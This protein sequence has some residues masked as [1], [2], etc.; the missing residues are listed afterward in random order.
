VR[1]D[2]AE[3]GADEQREQPAQRDEEHGR[4]HR[5]ASPEADAG[6]HQRDA[7]GDGQQDRVPDQAELRD[8][9]VELALEGRQADQQRAG[10][11]DVAEL[12]EPVLGGDVLAPGARRLDLED[13]DAEDREARAAEEQQVC[14]APERH[15]LAED[16]V[17][18]VV[19]R[20]RDE[21]DRSA[22]E[23]H[24]RAERRPPALGEA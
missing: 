24:Q 13:P 23:D 4:H 11:R 18:D 1:L 5:A 7:G 2:L 15:V 14:R 12:L 17:P 3:D 22:D 20:E 6:G 21:G 16:A 19:E 8:G 9:E 10:E